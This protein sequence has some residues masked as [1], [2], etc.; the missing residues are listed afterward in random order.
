MR[1]YTRTGDAGTTGLFG[2]ERVPKHDARVRAY[3]SVDELNA[4]LGMV[5]ALLDDPSLDRELSDLQNELFDVGA[6]LATP[7]DARPREEVTPI[8]EDDVA[9]LE[10][11]IDRFDADLE[12][13]RNFIL[14]GGHQASAALQVARAVARRAE[15]EVLWAA[16][17]A[18]LNAHVAVYLNRLSDLLFVLARLVNARHGVSESRWHV[19]G[20]RGRRTA[21]ARAR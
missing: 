14:P 12:P 1:I 8:D 7:L 17:Q 3:G 13:L 11:R 9:A 15:R 19:R 21:K 10:A 2:G 4:H 18:P 5:R 16:E 6:D 20:R